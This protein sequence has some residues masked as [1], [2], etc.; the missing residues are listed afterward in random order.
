MRVNVYDI[1]KKD[2]KII[3]NPHY[4]QGIFPIKSRTP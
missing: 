2:R 3:E 4:E 1:L